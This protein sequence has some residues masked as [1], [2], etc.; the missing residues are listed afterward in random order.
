MSQSHT[1]EAKYVGH[2][3][4]VV[5]AQTLRGKADEEFKQ[6]RIDCAREMNKVHIREFDFR[7]EDDTYNAQLFR[8]SAQRV[9]PV[10]LY[11]LVKD[12]TISVDDF[13]EIVTVNQ[14]LASDLLGDRLSSVMETYT[15]GL[16]LIITPVED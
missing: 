6:A 10:K 5:T 11:T 7:M 12:G 13:L 4:R 8:P 15:R 1:R 16:D 14:D 2:A 3:R 9:S